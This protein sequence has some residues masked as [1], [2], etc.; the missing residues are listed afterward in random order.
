MTRS[1]VEDDV[2]T[3]GGPCCEGTVRESHGLK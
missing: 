1:V 3:I 2:Y